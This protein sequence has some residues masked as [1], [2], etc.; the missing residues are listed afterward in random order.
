MSRIA[1]QTIASHFGLIPLVVIWIAYATH[2]IRAHDAESWIYEDLTA[3]RSASPTTSPS[4]PTSVLMAIALTRALIEY[5]QLL[6][7]LITDEDAVRYCYQQR[8]S[9]SQRK[10]QGSRDQMEQG[11][12]KSTRV[13]SVPFDQ[14]LRVIKDDISTNILATPSQLSVASDTEDVKPKHRGE[15]HGVNIPYDPVSICG[16]KEQD[17]LV[18]MEDDVCR[19][20]GGLK[21][22]E[23]YEYLEMPTAKAADTFE[24]K[25]L[26]ENPEIEKGKDSP[27]EEADVASPKRKEAAPSD[28]SAEIVHRREEEKRHHFE[29]E[30]LPAAEETIMDA[31]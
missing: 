7:L 12:S 4:W 5:F 27:V 1:N 25:P 23:H 10:R 3:H 30:L 17:Y 14:G 13:T 28:Y 31:F 20:C 6:H 8:C 15:T 22:V 16:C 9:A 26:T 24:T 11:E 2:S 29:D 19:P 18:A 21:R